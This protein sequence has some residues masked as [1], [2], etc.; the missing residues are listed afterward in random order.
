M[1]QVCFGTYLVLGLP[2]ILLLWAA[3]KASR[4]HDR[5]EGHDR[6]RFYRIALAISNFKN[7][8][9]EFD[10]LKDSVSL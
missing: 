7:G 6:Q 1:L 3:L 8:Q 4:L 9:G 10:L 5:E 2:A